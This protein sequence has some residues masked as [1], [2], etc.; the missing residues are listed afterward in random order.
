MTHLHY[1]KGIEVLLDAY[2]L[3]PSE[4]RKRLPLVITC[5]LTSTELAYLEDLARNR[6]IAADVIPTGLVS[7]E[8]LA[9]LYNAATMLVHASRYEGF[10]LPVLEAM[11]CGTPVITMASSSLP[12]VGGRRR[13]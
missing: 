2:A 9:V 1:S 7:D 8:E 11:Q 4:L 12:E 13:S 5:H 3:M 10:G 6:G